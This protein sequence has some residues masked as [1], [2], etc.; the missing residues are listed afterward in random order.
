MGSVTL[1]R[2]KPQ[3]YRRCAVV[4]TVGFSVGFVVRHVGTASQ[5]IAT[6]GAATYGSAESAGGYAG[7][8]RLLPD[9]LP[10]YAAVVSRAGGEVRPR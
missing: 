3:P 1:C 2:F 5:S 4:V 9:T 10:E 8:R 7:Q 6:L